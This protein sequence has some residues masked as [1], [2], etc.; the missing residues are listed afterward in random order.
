MSDKQVHVCE[1]TVKAFVVAHVFH[2]IEVNQEPDYGHHK[3]HDHGQG[4]QVKPD[5]WRES[6]H[7]DPGPKHLGEGADGLFQRKIHCNQACQDRRDPHR[8]DSN[9]RGHGSRQSSCG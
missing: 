8:P 1:E 7:F 4:I 6:G 5:F 9:G 3:D 2:G